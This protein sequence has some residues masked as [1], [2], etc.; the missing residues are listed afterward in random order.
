MPITSL[1]PNCVHTPQCL[2]HHYYRIVYTLHSAYHI[3]TT[4]LCTHSTVLITSLLPNCVHT[5]QCLSHHYYRIVY[6]LHSAYHIITTELCT[7]STVPITSLLPNCVHTPQCLSHHY[8]R[9]NFQRVKYCWATQANIIRKKM[10]E[11][12]MERQRMDE[13]DKLGNILK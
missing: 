6:T 12:F 9:I 11:L 2:S 3:I 5:P 10:T 7:H 4:E 13:V 1:L 8:Y